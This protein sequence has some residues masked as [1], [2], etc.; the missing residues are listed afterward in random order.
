MREQQ[1][2]CTWRARDAREHARAT[3]SCTFKDGVKVNMQ[4]SDASNAMAHHL[5]RCRRPRQQQQ[6]R[7][8]PQPRLGGP[9]P[10]RRLGEQRSAWQLPARRPGTQTG[11]ARPASKDSGA[12]ALVARACCNGQTII[13]NCGLSQF[14]V[15]D[16]LRT[17]PGPSRMLGT[18][19]GPLTPLHCHGV[20]PRRT[21][22]LDLGQGRE[23][24]KRSYGRF[25][26]LPPPY[27]RASLDLIFLARIRARTLTHLQ[28]D[29]H[30]ALHLGGGYIAN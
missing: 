23:T 1:A 2:S 24:A 29:W 11:S 6:Q 13:E 28:H 30:G 7:Q 16:R 19:R 26:N 14:Y 21:V 12:R 9:Q 20:L 8:Q 4:R 25:S 27:D 5:R 3:P 17:S 15:R 18:C 10:L 22:S